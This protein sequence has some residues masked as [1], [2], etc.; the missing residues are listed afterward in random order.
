MT[1]PP[2]PLETDPALLLDG[3]SLRT[4]TGETLATLAPDDSWRT[5]EG[6]RVH[7]LRL[8][9]SRLEAAVSESERKQAL[10][11]H[12]AAWLAAAIE[13]VRSLTQ[14]AE[15]I[16]TDEVWAALRMPPREPRHMGGLMRA[17]QRAGLIAPT[18]DHRP[19]TRRI[20]NSRPVR[21]WQCLRAAHDPRS[22]MTTARKELDAGS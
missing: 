7:A 11:A 3:R 14:T 17:C 8:P 12:D 13:D 2:R 1:A 19:S 6:A 9:M 15:T 5:P 4:P 10:S 20:N 18:S 22:A 21:I 16:T